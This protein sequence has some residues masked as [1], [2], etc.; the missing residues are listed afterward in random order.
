MNTLFFRLLDAEDKGTAL[1]EAVTALAQNPTP[2]A[3]AV[4]PRSFEQV[5]GT[6]FAYWVSQSILKLFVELPKLDQNWGELVRGPEVFNLEE[7]VR[8][9]TEVS[10][11]DIGISKRWCHYAKGGKFQRYFSDIHLVVD[12]GSVRDGIKKFR[13]PGDDAFYFRPGLTYTQRTTSDFNARI[14][15]SECLTS[16]KG[17]AIVPC[18]DTL[19]R[20]LALLC[21]VNT[22]FFCRLVELRVGA[23]SGA[24]RS[25]DLGILRDI[26]VPEP[27]YFQEPKLSRLL[28]KLALPA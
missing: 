9:W 24:A 22:E 13:R 5:P 25:Y 26:P 8:L 19:E 11:Q 2:E 7:F 10:H 4:N 28:L 6:P 27:H 21:I 15:P 14:L 17:P 18:N 3:F 1:Q 16:P 20:Y 12:Y 23:A